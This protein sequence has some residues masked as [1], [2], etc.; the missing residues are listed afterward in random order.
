MLISILAALDERNGI[1]RGGQLPWHLRD[2]LR[3]FR[4]LTMGHYVLMGRKTYDSFGGL[5]PGRKLVVLSRDANFHPVG[6]QV[7]TSLDAGIE[8]A[9]AG[10]EN[11]F[12]VIGGAQVF[13]HALPLAQRFY[14]TRVNTNADCDVFFPSFDINQWTLSAQ[15]E[16]SAGPKNDHDFSIQQ[17]ERA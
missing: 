17:L 13:A 11:E 9:R 2:D 16:F 1:G 15:K 4:R 7:A 5:M 6:A 3:N 8:I 10:G 14:L 12:F